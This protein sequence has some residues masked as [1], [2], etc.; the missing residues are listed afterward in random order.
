MRGEEDGGV[1]IALQADVIP[2]PSPRVSHVHRPVDTDNVHTGLL[3]SLQK[4]AAAVGVQGQRYG[5]VYCLD[6]LYD[7]LDVRPAPAVPLP[8]GQLSTPRVKDL[9]ITATAYVYNPRTARISSGHRY[10]L[11]E[12]D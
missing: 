12:P 4:T 5:W 9:Q 8:G 10:K 1:H 2:K 6:L 11:L 3:D 7:A